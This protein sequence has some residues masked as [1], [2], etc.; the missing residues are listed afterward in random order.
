MLTKWGMIFKGDGEF[1]SF[2]KSGLETLVAG[3]ESL[4]EAIELA[5]KWSADGIQLIEL[6]GWFGEEGADKLIAAVGDK[7]AVGYA[8]GSPKTEHLMKALFA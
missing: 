8:V 2:D 3:V 4:E 5:K 6:C 7:V 1:T